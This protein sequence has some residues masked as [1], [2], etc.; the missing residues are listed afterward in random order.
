MAIQLAKVQ[1]FSS[2]SGIFTDRHIF[3]KIQMILGLNGSMKHSEIPPLMLGKDMTQGKL[4]PLY[5]PMRLL[6]TLHSCPLV[7]ASGNA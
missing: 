4:G 1:I 3:G 7:E 6:L 2:R 5:T